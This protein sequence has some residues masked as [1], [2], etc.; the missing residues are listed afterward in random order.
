MFPLDSA[1]DCAQLFLFSKRLGSQLISLFFPYM[2]AYAADAKETPFFL[3]FDILFPFFISSNEYFLPI[4]LESALIEKVTVQPAALL[5]AAR[6]MPKI[7]S[8]G[9]NTKLLFG[10][11]CSTTVVEAYSP[12]KET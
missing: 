4:A 11:S 8:N 10:F 12:S 3:L 6:S 9:T 7:A 1:T 5:I 2:F